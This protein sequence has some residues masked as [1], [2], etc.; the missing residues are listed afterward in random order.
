MLNSLHNR[1]DPREL[2]RPCSRSAP[3]PLPPPHMNPPSS[4][5]PRAKFSSRNL[6]AVFKAPL[7]T[8]PLP[9]HAASGPLQRPNGRNMLVLGRAAVAAPAPINTPSLKRE[10]QAHEPHVSLVPAGSNWAENAAE[11]PQST[12]DNQ[13]LAPADVTG[14]T[15]TPEKIWTP[16]SV[17]EHLHTAAPSPARP[18]MK[19]ES[20]GR[21]GDDAVEHDIVQ[22]NFRRQ[23]QKERDFPDLKE[24]VQEAQTHHGQSQTSAGRSPSMGPQ[25]SEPHRGRATGRW[26]HFSEQEEMRRPMQD[27][28]WSH[29]R[30]DDERSS[31][32]RVSRFDDGYER[33]RPV[34]T[35]ASTSTILP[36]PNDSRTR[37]S[38]SDARFN[39]VASGE[40]ERVLSHSPH[41][42]D[43]SR[44]VGRSPS[45]APLN[46]P[47]GSRFHA[48][49]ANRSLT[50]S[51]AAASRSP[52]PATPPM[53]ADVSP[54]RALN[55]RR[56]SSPDRRP[57]RA[58]GPPRRTV[59]PWAQL[60]E[61]STPVAEAAE[62]STDSSSHSSAGSSPS[63]AQQVQL[64][65]RPQMLFDPKTGG[66]VAAKGATGPAKR[67]PGSRNG[68]KD[69]ESVP[70]EEP[71]VSIATEH[72][73]E[74]PAAAAE[75]SEASS[76]AVAGTTAQEAVKDAASSISGA[77]PATRSAGDAVSTKRS[78]ANRG[79]KRVPAKQPAQ[80]H[81][82]VKSN[83]KSSQ[84]K[85]GSQNAAAN[86]RDRTKSSSPSP[87]ERGKRN[88]SA[89]DE[90]RDERGNKPAQR[91]SK[92]PGRKVEIV[93]KEDPAG[94]VVLKK[95]VEGSAGGVVNVTSK[96]EGVEASP[97]DDGFTTVKP[98]RVVLSEKQQLRQRSAPTER[99]A[100]QE[101][102][103]GEE[104]QE[105]F[106][107]VPKVVASKR[108]AKPRGKSAVHQRKSTGHAT[109]ER[110]PKQAARASGQ[111][112]TVPAVVAGS[113]APVAGR[114]TEQVPGEAPAESPL[115]KKRPQAA[116]AAKPTPR[117]SSGK[118]T[119]KPDDRK[120]VAP[121]ARFPAAEK[122]APT[123]P[124]ASKTR[125]S[126]AAK[127]RPRQSR[128]MYVVKTPAPASATSTA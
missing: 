23:M 47:E 110:K 46:G 4:A 43:W 22:T 116:K 78:N 103:K 18:Q 93:K 56:A 113:P 41:R 16:E 52:A 14:A 3:P 96:Q 62:S 72:K 92:A 24:A 126:G 13:T 10:S 50:H 84:Q 34:E 118:S 31:R 5:K 104:V 35:P 74:K 32:D 28:R 2:K 64:L 91:R 15:V 102:S 8:K 120:T 30:Y 109:K 25:E 87:T 42:M 90:H 75:P 66:M 70:A 107:L 95:V 79:G 6:S 19:A 21:W 58:Q 48:R 7:R 121:A 114:P 69:R 117:K 29:D 1:K 49:H 85:R 105:T 9:D 108:A 11:K 99:A 51:P 83:G 20:A 26:A 27:D 106:G 119:R 55:W 128:Q 33:E 61:P 80:Q 115:S 38:R 39:M 124:G 63:L 17:A 76:A 82:V 57:D 81:A 89:R 73:E 127:A 122:R 54:A 86:A 40:S 44:P 65:K 111:K 71:T 37:F 12:K 59:T 68:S 123:A 60:D 36:V 77:E 100:S 101:Q 112:T 45:P 88:D 67:Q 53:N 97:G 98:R 94:V 125:A